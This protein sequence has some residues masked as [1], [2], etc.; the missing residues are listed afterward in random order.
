MQSVHYYTGYAL[1]YMVCIIIQDVHYYSVCIIIQDMHY[2]T[3]CIIIECIIIQDVHCYTGVHSYTECALLYR[4]CIIIE[5]ALLYGVYIIQDMN[6]TGCALL[7]W[8]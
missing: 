7:Y 6:H 3:G 2:Y 4:V 1:L 5:C 8:V